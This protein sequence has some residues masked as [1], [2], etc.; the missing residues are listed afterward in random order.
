MFRITTMLLT[1]TVIFTLFSP[2]FAQSP[3]SAP[4]QPATAPIMELVRGV[5][6]NHVATLT[7]DSAPLLR[8]DT[9]NEGRNWGWQGMNAAYQAPNADG[10]MPFTWKVPGLGFDG[11]GVFATPSPTQAEWKWNLTTSKA[12]DVEG[13]DKNLQP[14]G[15]VTVFL[16][17]TSAARRGCTAEPVLKPDN[18]GF[19]WEMLSG[20]TV[21]IDF[22]TPLKDL[23]FE[24]GHKNQ[25][26]CTI[27]ASPITIGKL[28]QTMTVTLPAGVSIVAPPE[29]RYAADPKN[30]FVDA[31]DPNASFIDMSYLNEMP[32]GKHGFLKT[33]GDQFV[34]SDGTPIRLW[35]V[36]VAA[37]SLYARTPNGKPNKPMIDIQAK[38]LAQLGF[39]LVR[40][41]H[42]DSQWVK[43]N[44]IAAG[45]T[46]DKLDDASVDEMFY[47]IKALKAQ[48]IYVWLDLATYR[49]FLPGDNIPAY[50]E[51]AAAYHA[52]G[53]KDVLGEGF[54]YLNARIQELWMT[55][56]KELLTRTNPYTGLA[57][58]DEPAMAGF[59]V[60]NENTITG[61]NVYAFT[62]NTP[63]HLA[64][65]RDAA[66]DF[67]AKTGIPQNQLT[68][69][70]AAGPSKLLMNDIEYQWNH[71]A[72]DYLHQLG[73]KVP[74][75]ASQ[76]WAPIISCCLPAEQAGD[77][78]DSHCYTD[79]EY[80]N[81]NPHYI[82]T[83][84]QS[85]AW[86][87]F[88]DSPKTISEYN[89]ASGSTPQLDGF[90]TLPFIASMA[91]FQ[92]WA[93]PMLFA[94]T[95]DG[96]GG[97]GGFSPWDSYKSPQTIGM[98]P[99]AALIYRAGNVQPAQTTVYLALTPDQ[100]L[101]KDTNEQSSLTIRTVQE[102][103]RLLVG[104]GAI[105]G[106]DWFKPTVAPAG[107]EV[108]TDL[109]HD[110][111]PPGDEVVSDT[112]ELRRNWIKGIY[113]VDTPKTQLAMGLL[114]GAV[115]TTLNAKF[116][117]DSP[118]AAVALSSLDNK[119][120]NASRRILLT[121]S[122]RF[123]C[124]DQHVLTEPV[125]GVIDFKSKVAGLRLIPL[126][127]DGTKMLPIALQQKGGAY[128]IQ[129]PTTLGTHWFLLEP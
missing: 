36:N 16:D 118:K 91:A 121:T 75:I 85:L 116:M 88:A 95:Q 14:H 21:S 13:T 109:Q 67:A 71:R 82:G 125:S 46:T 68:Q 100:A 50:D 113:V 92:G 110:F 29:E 11:G 23:Y 51:I 55:T 31:L 83:A 8:I 72:V 99:A 45:T 112:G 114:H 94:Y 64:K 119:P 2:A 58:K 10:S 101:Y 12:W 103:H 122:G 20:K 52:H 74:V 43:P 129:I 49:P 90:T 120:L 41:T 111:I 76:V 123:A 57:L 93:A 126:R 19:T 34:F 30:W 62:N 86:A 25:I 97:K 107:A 22:A 106:L 6:T 5:P 117:I 1:L 47:W 63:W 24:Q 115:I 104:I 81:A 54:S 4:G 69:P 66:K 39:N 33:K 124:K 38:R 9:L 61:V 79:P 84:F 59:M 35:G 127:N 53:S 80:I 87:H 40:L 77:V 37:Y 60:W 28:E 108:C 96:M 17:L 32:A 98:A 65:Y 48:G 7:V 26:R 89:I 27:Y 42:V 56:T 73:V 128:H 18:S 3:V 70:W 105:K 15:G 44:M 78:V 102:R